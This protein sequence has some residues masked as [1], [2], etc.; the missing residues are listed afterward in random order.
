VRTPA[1][2]FLSHKTMLSVIS[3]DNLQCF[4]F[5]SMPEAFVSLDDFKKFE[6]VGDQLF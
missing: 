3:K 5:G 2:S 6:M 1:L 4:F